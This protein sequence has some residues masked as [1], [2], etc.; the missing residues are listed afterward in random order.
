MIL[1]HFSILPSDDNISNP[2]AGPHVKQKLRSSVKTKE[3]MKDPSFVK[4]IDE[5]SKD[6][7]ILL[8]YMGDNR[9]MTALS[10]L[11]NLDIT[12]PEC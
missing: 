10:V 9:V 5:L 4:M 2:F 11:L 7:Q 8:K 1:I 6:T 3:Y 12:F